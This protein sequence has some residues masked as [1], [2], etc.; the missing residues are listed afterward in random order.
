MKERALITGTTSGIGKAFAEKLASQGFDLILVSRDSEKLSDQAAFLREKYSVEIS[1][2]ALD[3]ATPGSAMNVFNAVRD[4]TPGVS[5]IINNAGFN[6]AG[7]FMKTRMEKEAEMI[8]LHI[9]FTTEMMKLFIPGM[10]ERGYGC[11][12]NLGSTGSYIPCPG[13]AV[14][15]ATKAYIL[16]LSKGINAE[17]KGTGVSVTTLCPG[18]TNTEFALKAGILNTQ[19][20]QSNVME[21]EAVADIGYKAM[22][23][24]KTAVIAGSYNKMQVMLSKLLP[25]SIID[26]LAMKMLEQKNA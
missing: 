9:V 11:V 22:M 10:I 8:S 26:P 14:Y 20:F 1:C 3:L 7:K 21:P 6:E 16:S 18:P 24:R 13:D 23:Q 5:V 15:A 2:I 12:L 25:A 4:L 19:L 17:L